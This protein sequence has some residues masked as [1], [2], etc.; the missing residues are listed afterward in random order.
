M[1][2]LPLISLVSTVIVLW[3]L[4][5]PIKKYPVLFY[6]L[7]TVIVLALYINSDAIWKA[8]DSFSSLTQIVV[9]IVA[10]G[11]LGTS[12]FIIV[13]MIGALQNNNIIKKWFMPIRGE[14]SIIASIFVLLHNFYYGEYYFKILFTNPSEL[15]AYR[16]VATIVSL[17]LIAIMIPLFITSF[18]CVRNKMSAKKWKKLQKKAY[19]FYFLIYVHILLLYIPGYFTSLKSEPEYAGKYLFGICFYTIVYA[20]YAYLKFVR[21]RKK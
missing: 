18:K 1:N 4:K 9:L 12:M 2:Y 15:D 16:I 21:N 11:A 3:A 7:S 19:V 20:V 8:F 13:M 10:R 17:V 6:I 5:K 14:L